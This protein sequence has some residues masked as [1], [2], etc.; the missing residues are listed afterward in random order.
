MPDPLVRQSSVRR[1]QLLDLRPR[2]PVKVV[3]K[4][5]VGFVLRSVTFPNYEERGEVRQVWVGGYFAGE[6]NVNN[7]LYVLLSNKLTNKQCC[8]PSSNCK[9]VTGRV[10]VFYPAVIIVGGGEL[11]CQVD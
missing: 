7:C 2:I 4:T 9:M 6:V 11:S 5:A 8:V 10:G 3:N 1:C